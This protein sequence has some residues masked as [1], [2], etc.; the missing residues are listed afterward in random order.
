MT[1]FSFCRQCFCSNPLSAAFRQASIFSTETVVILIIYSQTGLSGST[2]PSFQGFVLQMRPQISQFVRIWLPE[3]R[4]S[5]LRLCLFTQMDFRRIGPGPLPKPPH[6]S[7]PSALPTHT[8]HAHTHT[9]ICPCKNPR[10]C[11][12]LLAALLHTGSILPGHRLRRLVRLCVCLGIYWC[13]QWGCAGKPAYMCFMS[14]S[15]F[16][17]LVIMLLVSVQK[18]QAADGRLMCAWVSACDSSRE[19]DR[20]MQHVA[21]CAVIFRHM[22]LHPLSLTPLVQPAIPPRCPAGKPIHPTHISTPPRSGQD[23]M[24]SPRL[25]CHGT[26]RQ[27]GYNWLGSASTYA[28]TFCWIMAKNNMTQL[29]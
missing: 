29:Y 23:T 27:N 19:G 22:T 14:F 28:F 24:F 13:T 2:L 3:C 26:G 15:C 11:P 1:E 16:F 5:Y 17:F 10:P 20:R 4:G 18:A 9:H 12:C 7:K 25:A 21:M 8:L 6:I